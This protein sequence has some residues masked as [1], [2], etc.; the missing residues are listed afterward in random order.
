MLFF[1][2]IP[3]T[4]AV[5]LVFSRNLRGGMF[6]ATALSLNWL[7]GAASY[8]LLPSLG[9]IYVDP[10]TFSSLAGTDAGQLQAIL[11]EQRTEFLRDPALG[12]RRAS[13][14][15]PRCTSRSSSR[16][17]S[18]PTCWDWGAR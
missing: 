5:A 4:L 15:S 9:P 11:L 16:P 12:R 18:P 8:F 3:G 13:A 2:F 17:R 6:Y 14:R 10:A 7:L 1:L